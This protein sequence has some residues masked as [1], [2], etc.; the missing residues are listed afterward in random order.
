MSDREIEAVIHHYDMLAEAGNDPVFDPPNL[1]EYMDKWDGSAFFSLLHID[2]EKDVLEIGCGSGRIAVQTAPLCRNF[3]GIDLSPKTICQITK[4]L[5]HCPHAQFICGDFL[6]YSF[7]R[8]F[9]IIYSTL[10]FMHIRDKKQ[11]IVKAANLLN[12]GGRF[13]LS[14]DKIREDVIDTGI[15]RIKIYPDDRNSILSCLKYAG[16]HIEETPETE[17]AYLF[18][19]VKRQ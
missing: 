2:A 16:L 19:A 9:D 8:T 6:E 10:T 13:I 5:S 3:L 17:F 15:S 18:A 7:E 1:K 4:N 12:N 14:I 11:A